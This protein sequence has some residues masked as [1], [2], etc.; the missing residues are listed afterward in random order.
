MAVSQNAL[1][2]LVFLWTCETSSVILFQFKVH[3]LPSPVQIPGCVLDP[4][5]ALF[6][7]D[8]PKMHQVR[9]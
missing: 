5:P 6:T 3:I 8:K 7:E 9:T 4:P 1:S 2:V